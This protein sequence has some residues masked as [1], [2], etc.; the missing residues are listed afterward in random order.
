MST[1]AK[2]MTDIELA[3]HLQAHHIKWLK[4]PKKNMEKSCGCDYCGNYT[5]E[6]FIMINE[7]EQSTICPPCYI[8]DYKTKHP[9]HNRHANTK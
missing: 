7:P 6:N 1:L 3:Y 9:E 8:E 2:D 5:H 4:N